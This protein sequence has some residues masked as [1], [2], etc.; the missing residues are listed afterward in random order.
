MGGIT[1]EEIKNETVDLVI[2]LTFFFGQIFKL[3]DLI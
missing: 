2:T 3:N 1:L